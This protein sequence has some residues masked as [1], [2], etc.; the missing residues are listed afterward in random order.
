MHLPSFT[1]SL[2]LPTALLTLTHSISPTEPILVK[3]P[4]NLHLYKFADIASHKT[5]R[6][7]SVASVVKPTT[8]IKH[9]ATG[10]AG[11][12]RLLF[13]L[14]LLAVDPDALGSSRTTANPSA[15]GATR[16]VWPAL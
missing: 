11:V 7:A 5:T 9:A 3:D 2:T 10:I 8:R 4:D 14:D 12:V 16:T 6:V 1:F 15:R 13:G